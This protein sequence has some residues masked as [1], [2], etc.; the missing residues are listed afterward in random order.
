MAGGSNLL[1]HTIHHEDIDKLFGI[2]SNED[3]PDLWGWA[4]QQVLKRAREI[5]DTADRREI[6]EA[7]MGLS[8]F[9]SMDIFRE[10]ITDLKAIP[11]FPK[12][13]GRGKYCP[14]ES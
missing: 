10:L 12:T 3:R 4:K 6:L 9:T 11:R 8:E 1:T 13:L 7:A 2:L 14:R 5:K